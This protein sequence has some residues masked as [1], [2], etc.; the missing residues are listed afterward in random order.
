MLVL[1]HMS[2]GA[3]VRAT[4]LVSIQ[5]VN[6]ENARCHRGVMIDQGI[7]TFITSYYKGFSAS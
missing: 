5:Q 1:V 3:P 2:A 7:V 6:S 4:E